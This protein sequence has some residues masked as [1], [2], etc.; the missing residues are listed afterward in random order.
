MLILAEAGN[1]TNKVLEAGASKTVNWVDSIRNVSRTRLSKLTV[2]V[3]ALV[4]GTM[5]TVHL[6]I[7]TAHA[8]RDPETI[9]SSV[10]V[11]EGSRTPTIADA[12]V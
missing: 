5:K 4:L 11:I 12:V 7:S 3:S 2:N 8:P 9:S 10:M 1:F 6:G